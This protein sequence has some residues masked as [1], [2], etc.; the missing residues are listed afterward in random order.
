[1]LKAIKKFWKKK[2]EPTGFQSNVSKTSKELVEDLENGRIWCHEG[3]PI[4]TE[5]LKRIV[6]DKK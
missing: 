3:R 4:V 5:L 2:P 1:M 6:L